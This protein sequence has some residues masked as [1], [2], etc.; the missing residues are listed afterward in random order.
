MN[1]DEHFKELEALVTN[2]E[3]SNQTIEQALADYEK[4]MKLVKQLREE[5]TGIEKKI[6]VINA[7]TGEITEI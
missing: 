1:I 5:L 7:E 6:Q 2:M 4:G 3:R